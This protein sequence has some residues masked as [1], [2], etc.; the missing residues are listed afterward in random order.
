MCDTVRNEIFG[1]TLLEDGFIYK[2]LSINNEE[3]KYLGLN[4]PYYEFDERYKFPICF[5]LILKKTKVVTKNEFM[6]ENIDF[7]EIEQDVK[8]SLKN[9]GSYIFLIKYDTLKNRRL[10]FYLNKTM[11]QSERFKFFLKKYK[12]N[13]KIALVLSKDVKWFIAMCYFSLFSF[14]TK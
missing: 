3:F 2:Q 7:F 13:S 9:I 8:S 10:V 12:Q 4:V 1:E 11:I 5:E 14:I 6:N